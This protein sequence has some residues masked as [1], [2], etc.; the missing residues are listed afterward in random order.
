MLDV[1]ISRSGNHGLAV[2]G[3]LAGLVTSGPCD[4][5]DG[6]AGLCDRGRRSNRPTGTLG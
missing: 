5:A 3:A 1:R 4:L 6:A 2:L